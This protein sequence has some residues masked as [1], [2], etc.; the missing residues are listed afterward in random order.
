MNPDEA[1]LVV[2]DDDD[3]R[4]SLKSLLECDGHFTLTASS[5]EE[6]MAVIE[7][8]TPICVLLDLNMPGVSGVELAERIRSV[9]GMDMVLIVLTGS[10]DES[11]QD[12]AERAGVDYVLHKPLDVAHL[13][14]LLPKFS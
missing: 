3:L 7:R 4:D 11:D 5:A 6:A 12:E 14:S 10:T 13:R 2:D 8:H 1:V 9:H